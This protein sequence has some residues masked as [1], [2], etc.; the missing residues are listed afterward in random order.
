MSARPAATAAATAA[1]GNVFVTATIRTSRGSRPARPAASA[2]DARIAPRRAATSRNASSGQETGLSEGTCDLDQGQP[3][4]VRARALDA[5]DQPDAA[6]LDR[7]RTG[8]P[9]ELAAGHVRVDRTTRERAEDDARHDVPA[10][11]EAP[12]RG[13]EREPR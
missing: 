3:D 6:S 12:A 7:V 11:M 13:E 4:H 1:G 9:L 10:G 8:F 2:I 5:L